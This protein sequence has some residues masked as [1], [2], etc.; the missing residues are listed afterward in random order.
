MI[1]KGGGGQSPR[2]SWGK[3]DWHAKDA[4]GFPWFSIEALIGLLTLN[5]LSAFNTAIYPRYT[6]IMSNYSI[7][8]L[9]LLI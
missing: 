8:Y 7:P 6:T 1:L 3:R 9:Y 2:L 4:G 5:T